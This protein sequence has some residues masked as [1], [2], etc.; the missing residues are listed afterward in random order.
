MLKYIAKRLII[1]IPTLIAISLLTFVIS[2]NA[3][4][5]PVE[6]MLNKNS[7]GEGNQTSRQGGE[8]AYVNLRHELGFDLQDGDTIAALHSNM[9]TLQINKLNEILLDSASSAHAVSNL[10]LLKDIID[11]QPKPMQ[12]V[13]GKI[14]F[15]TQAGRMRLNGKIDFFDTLAI[16][17]GNT[18]VVSVARIYD[19]DINIKWSKTKA[20]LIYKNKELITFERIGNIYIYKLKSNLINVDD[21]RDNESDTPGIG[22]VPPREPVIPKKSNLLSSSSSSSSSTVP[23]ASASTVA[24]N[25]ILSARNGTGLPSTLSNTTSSSSS[26]S[27][28]MPVSKHTS[29]KPIVPLSTNCYMEMSSSEV[30]LAGLFENEKENEYENGCSN[31]RFKI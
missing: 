1:F 4:G 12:A 7:G 21:K 9:K 10:G 26:S 18:N 5:D 22:I 3:P 14:T 8:I 23:A 11:I 16:K 2:I 20:V 30:L 17:N 29:M 28:S 25:K 31:S 19:A 13:T 27:S 24:R 6:A 15:I